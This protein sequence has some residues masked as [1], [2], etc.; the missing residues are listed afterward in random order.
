MPQAQG[1]PD[2]AAVDQLQA[3]AQ[4][5][6]GR[7]RF[8]RAGGGRKRILR[9]GR[10]AHRQY[11]AFG[12]GRGAAERRRPALRQHGA[13]E[14][15]GA[16]RHPPLADRHARVADPEPRKLPVHAPSDVARVPAQRSA[17]GAAVR[18]HGEGIQRPGAFRIAR[19]RQRPAAVHAGHRPPFR[20][21]ARR[22]RFRYALRPASV[23]RRRRGL[24][25][26]ALRRIRQ[27]HR[28]LAGRLQR[29]RGPRDARLPQQRRPQFLGRIGIQPVSGR[30]QG[31]R[32][33]GHRG[34]VAVSASEGI[35]P[36]L[37]ES[38]CQTGNDPSGASR[39]DL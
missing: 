7:P 24:S 6:R 16:G 22:H 36:E 17:R 21:W 5:R 38:R 33:D 13:D 26:R 11:S 12:R 39:F 32:A 15:G 25:Q 20:P 30:D 34:G 35:R 23:G 2:V 18:D 27:Q 37:P 14:S 19:R 9:R 29:R 8:Q 10:T 1:L 3:A 31:L 4:K 28:A